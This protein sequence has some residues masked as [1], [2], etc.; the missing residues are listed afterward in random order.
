MFFCQR[1]EQG[2]KTQLG[3]VYGTPHGNNKGGANG[4]EEAEREL[5]DTYTKT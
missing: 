4:G 2:H 1:Q 3:S 5:K